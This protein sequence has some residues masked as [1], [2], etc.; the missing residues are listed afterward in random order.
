MKYTIQKIGVLLVALV[1]FNV[2]RIQAQGTAFP[3]S[4]QLQDGGVPANGTYD[5][6]FTLYDS[7]TDGA[8]LGVMTNWNTEV[9]AGQY[10]VVLDFGG[11]FDGSPRWLE[12]AARTNGAW[13]YTTLTPR[14]PLLP[15]PYAIMAGSASNLLGSLPAS[16]LT[17]T[18]PVAQLP[19]VVL[20]NNASAVQLNGSFNGAFSGDGG[21]VTNLNPADLT[22]GTVTAQLGLTNPN[23]FFMGRFYGI[24]AGDGSLVTNLNPANLTAGTVTA[25]LDLTNPN[26]YFMGRFYGIHAGDG[27]LVTNLNPANLTAGTVTAQLYLTNP[28]NYFMG[29]FYG[30]YTGDHYHPV[31]SPTTST[32]WACQVS[33]FGSVFS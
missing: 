8:A 9:T 24:H 32:G 11:V 2:Q 29:R 25:Q 27:S 33:R 18:L 12:I 19:D 16:Q 4:G 30:I 23:N 7:A 15:V 31:I 5:V 21:L 17:G 1:A 14:Q 28:N 20:T 26:N 13:A 22:A 10:S 6:M 3:Y